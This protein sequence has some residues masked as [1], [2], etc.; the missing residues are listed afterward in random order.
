MKKIKTYNQ[1]LNEAFKHLKGP[2]DDETDEVF[3]E[4]TPNKA[5]LW[6]VENDLN[7]YVK[8]AINIG[9]DINHENK[10]GVTALIAASITG[11]LYIVKI[12]VEAGAD[13]NIQNNDGYTAL[14][15]AS[16]YG[17]LDIVKYLRSK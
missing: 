3:N 9:A 11:K 5:L 12:L 6:S 1:F 17:Y 8:K 14:M 2:S 13:L 10:N 4:M 15:V 16:K 7:D